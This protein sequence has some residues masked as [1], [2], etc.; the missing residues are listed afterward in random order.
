MLMVSGGPSRRAEADLVAVVQP[1]MRHPLPVHVRAVAAVLVDDH[2]TVAGLLDQR[3]P[4]RH[5][6]QREHQMALRT[7][8]DQ[9]L[10]LV[11]LDALRLALEYVGKAESFVGRGCVQVCCLPTERAE[12][13]FPYY[14]A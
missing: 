9:Y 6:G 4:P 3:V 14:R 1:L 12:R 10:G 11:E 8:A 7:A 5:A 2:P 13:L